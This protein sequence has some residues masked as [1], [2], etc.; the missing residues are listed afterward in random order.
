M[1]DSY[2]QIFNEEVNKEAFGKLN[3]FDSLL[4]LYFELCGA[5]TTSNLPSSKFQKVAQYLVQGGGKSLPATDLDLLYKQTLTR[6]AEFDFFAFI[7]ACRQASRKALKSEG[8]GGLLLLADAFSA[9]KAASTSSEAQ[10]P[11]ARTAN[12]LLQK[13]T[14]KTSL[15]QPKTLTKLK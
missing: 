8:D 12:D 10:K 9:A 15:N 4:D 6:F 11:K 2:T 13:P 14:L 5:K 7:D 1:Y 3:L